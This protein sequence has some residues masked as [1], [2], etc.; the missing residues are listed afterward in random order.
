MKFSEG[1]L[2]VQIVSLQAGRF[3]KILNGMSRF[4]R[5]PIKLETL[6]FSQEEPLADSFLWPSLVFVPTL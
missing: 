4:A 1:D 3:P 6:G 2:P 5:V